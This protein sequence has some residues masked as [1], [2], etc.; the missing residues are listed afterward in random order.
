MDQNILLRALLET[1][2]EAV[3]VVDTGGYTVFYN[4]AAARLDGLEAGEVIGRHLLEV[5][6][7]LTRETSTLLRVL[8]TRQAITD[9]EQSYITRR[10]T[11]V[12]T[13]NTTVPLWDGPVLVG[14]L[15][16]SRDIT[17]VKE[18]SETVRVLRTELYR[19]RTASDDVS[20][21]PGSAEYTMDD[22]IG[23]DPAL[24]AVKNMAARAAQT[25][26]AVFVHG[27]TGTGKELLVQAI[28]NASKR[29][30]APFI[31]QNC[32]ALP[33]SLLEGIFFGTMRGGFT[34]ATDREGLFELASGGTLYLDE[35]NSMPLDLQAKLLRVI[36]TGEVRRLGDLKVRRVDVR[37]IAS[38][39]LPPERALA[40][41]QIRPDLYYRLNT[42]VLGLPP[43]RERKGDIPLLVDWFIEQ[44][45]RHLGRAIRG[46]SPGAL[47]ELLEYDWPGN[48]RELANVIEGAVAL[49]TGTI[50]GIE[51][52]PRAVRRHRKPESQVES[53]VESQAES[54]VVLQ[55]EPRVESCA[56]P[57]ADSDSG[58][59][60]VASAEAFRRTTLAFER[61]LIRRALAR[62]EGNITRTAAALGIP[63]TTLQYKVR[64]LGL[65]GG[66]KSWQDGAGSASRR[67]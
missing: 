53:R 16:V 29:R 44:N 15:E 62:S 9:Q 18:L 56:E 4:A 40:G 7:S 48:V 59:G 41:G 65:D 27:E 32:C 36:E 14:A 20:S 22:I 66:R 42:V 31:A 33:E 50:I 64:V 38:S 43:L 13:I 67:K 30:R 58:G 39:S 19:P 34:G 11:T 35:L 54:G 23:R 21:T 57:R 47:T 1:M 6:P 45:N 5:Y 26:V 51:D 49:A 63:R 46:C 61:D 24:L 10:G 17:S 60:M 2:D 55:T 28:H 12:H 52:L 37:I 8:R 25:D 3:H